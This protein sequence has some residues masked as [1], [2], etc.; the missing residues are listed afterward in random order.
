M[1][2]ELGTFLLCFCLGLS[3]FQAL[4][5]LPSPG[6]KKFSAAAHPQSHWLLALLLVLCLL[7]L[8]TLRL[9][10]DFSVLNVAQHSN[11]HLPLLYKIT[12]AWGNHEGSMLLF[13]GVMALFGLGLALQKNPAHGESK[14]LA[15]AVQSLMTGAVLLF[16]LFTSNPFE[17]Q[18]PPPADGQMLNPLLQDVGLALHPPMLYLGY[19]GFS[20][21]FSLAVGAMLSPPADMRRWAAAAHP[22]ILAAWSTLTLGIGLGSWWAYREL[23]WGGWWFWDPVENASLMPWLAGTALLHANIV[24]KKRGLLAPW[25]LLLSIITFG[26]SLLGTFLVRSGA[27]TSVHGFASDPARGLFILAFLALGLGVALT[28]FALKA[29]QFSSKE[30]ALPASREGMILINNMFVLCACASVLLGTLYPLFLEWMNGQKITVGPAFFNIAFLPLMALPLVFAGL[31]PFLAWK[32]ASFSQALKRAWPSLAACGAGLLLVLALVAKPGALALA[33]FGLATWLAASS[34][35]WLLRA[36]GVRGA[37]GVAVAH[38]GVAVLVAGITGASLWKQEI[39]RPLAVGETLTVA[40]Y[41]LSFEREWQE[42]T[43]LYQS[44]HAEFTLRAS[45]GSFLARLHPQYRRYGKGG[46]NT[47]EVAAFHDAWFDIHVI[48]GDASPDG[49]QSA[50]RAYYTP[51]IGCIWLGCVLMTLGGLLAWRSGQRQREDA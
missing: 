8:I 5:L 38:L 31:A 27:L 9:D 51:L 40:G 2:A 26:L 28:L 37:L 1:T 35:Q 7:L 36:R 22:F 42:T 30:S 45:D 33:G 24:L 12:G 14:P 39:E 25:V 50:A 21:V 4:P 15:L 29:P 23:G 13:A 43:P 3:L 48:I 47:H 17:R 20:L 10:D 32:N 16:I 44:K 19:V 6:L 34:L 46:M 11:I 49:K 41:T 18:F